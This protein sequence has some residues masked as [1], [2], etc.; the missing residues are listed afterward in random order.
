MNQKLSDW[1]SLAEIVSGVAVVVT[2]MFLIL[3]VRENTEVARAASYQAIQDGINRLAEG[4]LHDP[5]VLSVWRRFE[6]GVSGEFT[7]AE[8]DRLIVLLRIAYRSYETAY[9]SRQY[10]TLG[11]SEWARY[12]QQICAL[13]GIMAPSIRSEVERRLSEE[14]VRAVDGSCAD[15]A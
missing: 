2:L 12:E 1:A 10:G 3:G 4:M 5:E 11:S 15:E 13:N 6:N 8:Q 14:F 9:Y 7:E